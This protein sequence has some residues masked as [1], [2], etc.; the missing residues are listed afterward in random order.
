M[1][2]A[3]AA[4]GRANGGRPSPPAWPEARSAT[5]SGPAGG[6]GL[7]PEGECHAGTPRSGV[8]AVA[9]ARAACA[10]DPELGR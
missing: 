7:R 10:S 5:P 9:G 6:V 2:A 4:G 1:A 8:A 3:A